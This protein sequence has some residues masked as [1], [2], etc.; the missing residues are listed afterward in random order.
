MNM[1]NEFKI[2]E[3]PKWMKPHGKFSFNE[4]RDVYN[5]QFRFR[6]WF[7]TPAE[8]CSTQQGTL[9]GFREKATFRRVLIR[10]LFRLWFNYKS[11][12]AFNVLKMVLTDDE[13]ADLEA[14]MVKCRYKGQV[15]HPLFG[16]FII[17]DFKK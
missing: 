7:K 4:T 13:L 17:R 3:I 11:D 14:T 9:F 12:T 10:G 5:H 8:Y 16:Y 15:F 2:P 6:E 1:S